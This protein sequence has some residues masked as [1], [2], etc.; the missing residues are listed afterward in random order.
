MHGLDKTPL[1]ISEAARALE[2]SEQVVRAALNRG[3]LD[4]FR[5]GRNWR[6][7]PE[8]VERFLETRHGGAE[9]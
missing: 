3:D 7:F 4:G 9:A 6:V 8:S 5:I 2:V 1:S